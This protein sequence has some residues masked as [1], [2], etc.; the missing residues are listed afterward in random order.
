MFTQSWFATA[1]SSELAPGQILARDFL[2]GRIVLF[3]DGNGR[4][5]AMSA[6]C[7]HVGADLSL[8]RLVGNNIQCAFHHWEYGQDG[9]CVKTGSGDPAPRNACLFVFPT[10]ERFGIIWVFNGEAPLFALPTF[11]HPDEDLVMGHPYT[12]QILNSDPWVF[13]ANTPD[14]QHAVSVH[15]MKQVEENFHDNCKWDEFGFYFTYLGRDQDDIPMETTL[16]IRGT[17]IFYRSGQHGD[18]WRGSIVGF[19]IPGQMSMLASNFVLKGPKA[20]EQ[21][22]FTNAVSRRTLGEDRDI[23][24]TVHYRPGAMTKEDRSLARFLQYVRNYPR[25]HPSAEFIH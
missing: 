9:Y 3:R 12:P 19:G 15:K 16:A 11:P 18:F 6:Y 7:A 4:A 20:E 1:M 23:I 24:N 13:C 10:E 5:T 17:S 21:L 25:A 8:G 14:R 2:D 22:E